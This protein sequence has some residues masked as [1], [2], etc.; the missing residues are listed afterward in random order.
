MPVNMG[1]C[2]FENTY[3]AM[4]ECLEAVDRA[5]TVDALVSE[6]NEYEKPYVKKFIDLC[7]EIATDFGEAD[8]EKMKN[9][10]QENG[11]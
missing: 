3:N 4:L 2:R 10:G 6:V 7:K 8:L 9:R 11:A 5:E 1:Y